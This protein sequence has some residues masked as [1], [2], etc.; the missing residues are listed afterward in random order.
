MAM[1]I[2]SA[3]KSE[4]TIQTH[5]FQKANNHLADVVPPPTSCGYRTT[6]SSYGVHI[7]D[8]MN[9]NQENFPP[10]TVPFPTQK[11]NQDKPPSLYT[12]P[13][14]QV[15]QSVTHVDSNG[16]RVPEIITKVMICTISGD[17]IYLIEG[18]TN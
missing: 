12:V 9:M 11:A 4:A 16:T 15:G 3:L 17:S 6:T 13:N 1:N 10:N 5:R 14:L 8:K 18:T 7:E 2:N